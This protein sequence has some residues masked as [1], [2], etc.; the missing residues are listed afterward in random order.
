MET[1]TMWGLPLGATYNSRL[2]EGNL[3]PEVV[4]Y[5][6]QGIS[7]SIIQSLLCRGLVAHPFRGWCVQ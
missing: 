6:I 3:E 2:G 7:A 1:I 4:Y 5:A